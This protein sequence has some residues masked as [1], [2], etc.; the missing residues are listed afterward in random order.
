MKNARTFCLALLFASLSNS[1]YAQSVLNSSDPVVTYDSLNKPAEP[2]WGQI[3]KWVRT[4]RMT[5]N[6]DAYKAYIYKGI[7]FRLKFPKSYDAAAND[8]K[9]YPM[10]IF[11]HGLGEAATIYDNEFHL[12]LGCEFFQNAIENGTFDGY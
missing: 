1:L 8:G 2:A 4:P 7:A 6:T 12:L 11:W 5:W 3:G 10:L 9:K